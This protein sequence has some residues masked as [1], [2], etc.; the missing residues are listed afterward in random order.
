MIKLIVDLYDWW[1]T[2]LYDA[3]V[4]RGA[5]YLDSQV[6]DTHWGR[7]TRYANWR[8]R[9]DIGSLNVD[10]SSSCVVGQLYR[11]FN[12]APEYHESTSWL[13]RRGFCVPGTHWK[14]L[15]IGGRGSARFVNRRRL[16]NEAWRRYV[17]QERMRERVEA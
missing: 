10:E 1:V 2:R 8:N 4:R 17:V 6:G 13:V 15:L 16:L 7:S 14:S 3:R 9:I 5:A 12:Y 11:D